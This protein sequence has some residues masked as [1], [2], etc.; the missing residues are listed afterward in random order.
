[1][2]AGLSA[3]RPSLYGLWGG[4]VVTHMK[5]ETVT[6]IDCAEIPCDNCGTKLLIPLVVFEGMDDDT[7]VTISDCSWCGGS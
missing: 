1:M 5:T 3:L 2:A 7:D 4:G 6:T